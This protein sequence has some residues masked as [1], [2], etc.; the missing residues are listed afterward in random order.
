MSALRALANHL[1][2]QTITTGALL[3]ELGVL[4]LNTI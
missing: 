1:L 4:H 2:L 3:M